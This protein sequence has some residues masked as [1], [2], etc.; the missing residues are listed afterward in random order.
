[1]RAEDG[2]C[3][4]SS[5]LRSW[6]GSRTAPCHPFLQG[7]F[8]SVL[9][10][11]H[12][13]PTLQQPPRQSAV[14]I[15][16][17]SQPMHDGLHSLPTNNRSLFPFQTQSALRLRTRNLLGK[18]EDF[19]GRAGAGSGTDSFFKRCEVFGRNRDD[20]SGRGSSISACRRARRRL[21]G[22][23]RRHEYPGT[24]RAGFSCH[25]SISGA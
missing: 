23:V 17:L 22:S 11:L 18:K 25:E 20:P 12:V 3:P 19:A 9:E 16:P 7:R 21:F 6:T 8:S 15:M 10:A 13:D 24:I 14:A 1:M 2:S 4:G 5:A